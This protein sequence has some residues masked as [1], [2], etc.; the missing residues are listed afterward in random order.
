LSTGAQA[1]ENEM[2]KQVR[3]QYEVSRP[4]ISWYLTPALRTFVQACADGLAAPAAGA[5][6]LGHHRRPSS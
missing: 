3:E 6:R 1:E 5:A 4:G 2:G